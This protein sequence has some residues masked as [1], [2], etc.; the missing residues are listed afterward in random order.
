MATASDR[1]LTAIETKGELI[2]VLAPVRSG[3]AP[4]VSDDGLATSTMRNYRQATRLFFRH[5][6]GHDWADEIELGQPT[7]TPIGPNDILTPDESDQLLAAAPNARDTAL[8]EFLAV[9]GQRI[10]ATLSIRVGGIELSGEPGTVRLNDEVLRHNGADGPRPVLW[11]GPY[12]S[13]WFESHPR[14]QNPEAPLFCMIEADVWTDGDEPA[15][16]DKGDP[17]TP[18]QASTPLR[19]TAT[20]AGVDEEKESPHTFHHPDITWMRERGMPDEADRQADA[21]LS[22]PPNTGRSSISTAAASTRSATGSVSSTSTVTV[23]MASV[24]PTPP[25]AR[26]RPPGGRRDIGASGHSA[27]RDGRAG[28]SRWPRRPGGVTD[29]VSEYDLRVAS[30]FELGDSVRNVVVR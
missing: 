25:A 22:S 26:S 21:P 16:W 3:D 7:A 8:V 17:L 27:S 11:A 24:I 13:T 14:L 19:K 10:T 28:L 20:A 30:V 5:E 18:T 1:L 9:T 2:D 15:T 12:I 6:L 23:P 4:N 29:T